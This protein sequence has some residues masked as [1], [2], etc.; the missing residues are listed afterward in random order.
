MYLITCAP[1]GKVYVGQSVAS[2]GVQRRWTN[3]L[4]AANKT[5]AKALYAAIRKYGPAA[6]NVHTISEAKTKESLDNLESLHIIAFD[7]TNPEKGY[8]RRQGGSRG[9]HSEESKQKM[10][11]S[12]TGR[13][14]TPEWRARIAAGLLGK[15]KTYTPEGLEGIRKSTI[16][17]K[18]GAFKR[19]D[20]VRQRMSLAMRGVKR[21]EE[22]K[23]RM[24]DAAKLRYLSRTRNES[25]R[26]V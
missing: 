6:F 1:N 4:S 2:Q 16:G 9:L 14:I 26:F 25:G 8:N 15:K 23:K 17:N 3:H 19:S 10:S 18:H 20:E 11:E 22:A 5:T 24:S 13:I 21:S 7:S 12:R